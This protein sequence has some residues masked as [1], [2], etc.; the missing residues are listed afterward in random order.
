MHSDRCVCCG[1]YVPEGT[2]V[3][4]VCL[5]ENAPSTEEKIQQLKE[6]LQKKHTGRKNVITNGEL[7][8]IFGID[9]RVIQKYVKRLRSRGIPICSCN[10]GY[11]YAVDQRDINDTV[12]FLNEKVTGTSNSRTS[13]L[14]AVISKH[15]KNASKKVKKIRIV[16][17]EEEGDEEEFS[18][19]ME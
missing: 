15:T 12:A 9:G 10:E 5:D 8:G 6:Y 4:P 14:Y 7:A 13:L 16:M 18:I 3:C 19:I 11:F 2:M 17:E 1:R